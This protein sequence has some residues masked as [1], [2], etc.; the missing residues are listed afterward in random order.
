[1]L[2]MRVLELDGKVTCL[3]GERVGQKWQRSTGRVALNNR[4]QYLV[5]LWF[6]FKKSAQEIVPDEDSFEAIRNG[7]FLPLSQRGWMLL[8]SSS[9]SSHA[10]VPPSNVHKSAELL[11]ILLTSDLTEC[12]LYGCIYWTIM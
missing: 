4:M 3:G 11:T 8:A 5:S 12:S 7:V 9:F 6:G 10:V 1:M 2:D